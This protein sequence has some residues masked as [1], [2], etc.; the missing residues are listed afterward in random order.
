MDLF[1]LISNKIDKKKKSITRDKE[2]HER[3]MDRIKGK[4]R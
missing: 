4:N 3:K 1:I 2:G